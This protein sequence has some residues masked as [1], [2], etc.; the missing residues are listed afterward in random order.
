MRYLSAYT[1][2][3]KTFD[4]RKEGI[5]VPNYNEKGFFGNFKLSVMGIICNSPAN[6]GP[7]YLRIWH[8]DMAALHGLTTTREQD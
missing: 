6:V 1:H 8:R 5:H 7:N 2:T 3:K 4:T